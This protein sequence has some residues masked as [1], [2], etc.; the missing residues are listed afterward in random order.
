[1]GKRQLLV[2]VGCGEWRWERREVQ[3]SHKKRV[4]F[5]EAD[6]TGAKVE[7]Y[8]GH[9]DMKVYHGAGKKHPV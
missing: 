2:L 1:M 7:R 8:Q 6:D 5:C 3:S 4:A 9:S